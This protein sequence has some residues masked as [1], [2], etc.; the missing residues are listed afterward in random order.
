MSYRF[1]TTHR[2]F[3][4]DP[5]APVRGGVERFVGLGD[6]TEILV[7]AAPK[8]DHRLIWRSMAFGMVTRGIEGGNRLSHAN[9]DQ[10]FLVERWCRLTNMRFAVPIYGDRTASSEP[11]RRVGPGWALGYYD[12]QPLGGFVLIANTLV[13]FARADPGRLG[14]GEHLASRRAVGR[15]ID[16]T[17]NGCCCGGGLLARGVGAGRPGAT[18][19]LV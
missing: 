2:S 1:Q 18:R 3:D 13:A 14:A 6:V 19:P 4:P 7:R 16:D 9:H 8:S 15:G 10:L 12:P 5:V 11:F 17:G